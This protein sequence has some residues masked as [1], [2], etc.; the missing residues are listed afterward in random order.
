MPEG[1]TRRRSRRRKRSRWRP[2]QKETKNLYEIEYFTLI[3]RIIKGRGKR[4]WEKRRKRKKGVKV[5]GVVTTEKQRIPKGWLA[6]K[7]RGGAEPHARAFLM[8]VIS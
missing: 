8:T 1:R 2:R 7:G 4:E 6:A 5:E 3:S